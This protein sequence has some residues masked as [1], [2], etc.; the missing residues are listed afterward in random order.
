M[1]KTTEGPYYTLQFCFGNLVLD[2][3]HPIISYMDRFTQV[4]FCFNAWNGFVFSRVQF[5]VFE[6]RTAVAL[7]YTALITHCNSIFN[8]MKLKLLCGSSVDSV[9]FQKPHCALLICWRL[10]SCNYPNTE[11]HQINDAWDILNNLSLSW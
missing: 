9:N 10:S 4:K 8:F 5:Q 2:K 1:S 11:A 6:T 7:D 3:F